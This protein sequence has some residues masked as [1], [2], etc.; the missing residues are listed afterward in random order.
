MSFNQRRPE[1]GGVFL[2]GKL[3]IFDLYACFRY[4]PMRDK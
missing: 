2:K 4:W 3:L 1:T